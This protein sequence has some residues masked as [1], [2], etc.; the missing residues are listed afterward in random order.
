MSKTTQTRKVYSPVLVTKY[1]QRIPG[2]TFTWT[3]QLGFE[4]QRVAS[5]TVGDNIPDFRS[6]IANGDSATTSLVGRQYRLRTKPL[7]ASGFIPAAGPGRPYEAAFSLSGKPGHTNFP[8]NNIDATLESKAT[9]AAQTAF[10]KQ[11][12]KK[13]Q[14]FAAGT[15]CGE[16]METVRMLAS[17]AKSLRKEVGHLLDVARRQKR[18]NRNLAS[19]RKLVADTWLEWSFGVKPLIGD[20]NDAAVAFERMAQGQCIDLIRVTAEGSAEGY[21]DDGTYEWSVPSGSPFTLQSRA[22]RKDRCDVIYRGAIK[23]ANP[24]GEMPLPMQF[25]LDLSSILPTAWE[26]VPWSFFVDY[27]TNVGDAIDAWSMRFVHFSWL[28]RT[29]RNSRELRA[30]GMRVVAPNEYRL[31]GVAGGQ[32]SG[33]ITAV[34]RQVADNNFSPDLMLR[35]PGFTGTKWINIAALTNGIADLKRG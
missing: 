26:L 19:T 24:S 3:R 27:F 16:L 33:K 5:R 2:S 20:V 31:T 23:S 35:I 14:T 29:V 21:F 4:I 11:V 6:K 1:D 13:T 18:L 15:F 8:P 12:R 17:P 25:G 9:S 28:N 30:V 22:D 34:D 10:A 7:T 32:V